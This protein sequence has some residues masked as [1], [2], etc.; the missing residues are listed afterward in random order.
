MV[1]N[2]VNTFEVCDGVSFSYIKSSKFKNAQLSFTF[3][4]QLDRSLVSGLSLL[5]S[6]LSDSCDKFRNF[7][8][9]NKYLENTYGACIDYD[10]FKIGNY[11]AINLSVCA[12][13][14][15]FTIKK[16]ENIKKI[17]NLL[18]ELVFNPFVVDGKFEDKIVDK[19]KKEIIELIAG[20][21]SDKR[22]WSVI[23]CKEEMFKD[24]KCGISKY[25]TIS[26][27]NKFDGKSLFDLYKKCL[28]N[29]KVKVV[30]IS[31]SDYHESFE[32]IKS[33]FL[34]IKRN[35][36]FKFESVKEKNP[37][38][39][40]EVYDKMNIQQC[41]LVMGF[42]TPFIAPLSTYSMSL[43]SSIYGGIPT[44][45][46]FMNVR[47]KLNLCYY[48][49]S[50]FDPST[51]VLYVESGVEENNSEKA[52]KEIIN[53]LD[54]MRKG[55]ISDDEIEDA[56]RFL[57]QGAQTVSDNLDRMCDWY[58][59]RFPLQI[60]ETPE[61]FAENIKKVSKEEIVDCMSK[62]KLDTVY[63]LKGE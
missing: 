28:V 8:D 49:S 32:K 30:M 62:A 39:I 57:I 20:E 46:L 25:G 31:N 61:E 47:E 36:D 35:S 45:K 5:I 15:K 41:K 42:R 50:K 1:K 56:K 22:V 11:H 23:R 55:E 52:K 24:E 9:L 37:D 17:V 60:S 4:N 13:D 34:E 59:L 58:T 53:Q 16:G 44:S 43:S 54:L 2:D 29:S 26:D 12:L 48:C 21:M 7:R 6:V 40:S 18:C 3:F 19:R 14:D 38:S 33:E 63:M 10:I 27:V 51:G